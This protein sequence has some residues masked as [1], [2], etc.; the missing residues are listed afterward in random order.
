ML[1]LFI[2]LCTFAIKYRQTV[3]VEATVRLSWVKH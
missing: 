1:S 3:S 2:F